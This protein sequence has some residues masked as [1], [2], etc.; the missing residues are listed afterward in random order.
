MSVKYLE[1]VLKTAKTQKVHT[2]AAALMNMN[3]MEGT[4]AKQLV[5]TVF[6]IK[7]AF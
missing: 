4:P 3:F 2:N 7:V 5:S 6:L 1:S